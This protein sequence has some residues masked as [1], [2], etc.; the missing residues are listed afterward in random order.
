MEATTPPLVASLAVDTVLSASR[1]A[2]SDAEAIELARA[3]FGVRAAAVRDL[4]SE[5]DRTFA[6]DAADGAPVAILKVSNASEDPEV[7]DMEAEAALHVLAG[8]PARRR[9]GGGGGGG[10][11]APPPPPRQHS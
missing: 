6:L 5:R 10:G 1:P 3:C 8:G 9:G 7:L 2:L 11:G 4:G